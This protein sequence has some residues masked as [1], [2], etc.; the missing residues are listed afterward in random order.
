M[1]FVSVWQCVSLCLFR[2]WRWNDLVQELGSIPFPWKLSL[3]IGWWVDPHIEAEFFFESGFH[4]NYWKPIRI[5][6][7]VVVWWP[8]CTLTA[9]KSRSSSDNFTEL[10]QLIQLVP[11]VTN[12]WNIMPNLKRT[13]GVCCF[14]R[15]VIDS[16]HCLLSNLY[17]LDQYP[18]VRYAGDRA[19][20]GFLCRHWLSSL[21]DTHFESRSK[22]LFANFVNIYWSQKQL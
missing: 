5:D 11:G 17:V 3:I 15:L 6:M 18:E 21:L 16:Y 9:I 10:S 1:D 19:S 2:S 22:P 13:A 12:L 20:P 7:V 8:W 4:T 14:W